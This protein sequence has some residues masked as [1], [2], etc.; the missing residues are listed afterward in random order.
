MLP[1]TAT[2][3]AAPNLTSLT[4]RVPVLPRVPQFQTLPPCR[5][6]HRCYHV[7]RGSGSLLPTEKGSSVAMCPIA[8]DLA[9]PLRRALM[10]PPVP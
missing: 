7:S 10:L 2:C 5:G 4:K 1:R 3:P 8:L 6:G 9:S